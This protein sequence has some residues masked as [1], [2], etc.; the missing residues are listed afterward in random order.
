[1][2][3]VGLDPW[4]R[5]LL[6][7]AVDPKAMY[8]DEEQQQK[9]AA[10]PVKTLTKSVLGKAGEHFGASIRSDN[11]KVHSPPCKCHATESTDAA[12]LPLMESYSSVSL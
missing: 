10:K 7:F 6:G 1:M 3:V 11:Q 4:L 9:P 5:M 2:H 12:V 8:A